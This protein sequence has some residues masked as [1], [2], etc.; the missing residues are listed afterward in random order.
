[1]KPVTSIWHLAGVCQGPSS[2]PTRR[3]SVWPWA[4][5]APRNFGL[6]FNISATAEARD[7]KLGTQL[8]FAKD[9]QKIHTGERVSVAVG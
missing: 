3:K 1:M 8:Q 5:G 7:F 4:R 9:H 2:N 6:P